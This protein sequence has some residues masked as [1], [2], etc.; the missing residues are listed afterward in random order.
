MLSNT[1]MPVKDKSASKH[2]ESTS[3]KLMKREKLHAM[4]T[5]CHCIMCVLA[6]PIVSS[7]VSFT[8]KTLKLSGCWCF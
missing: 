3:L 6:F 7:L 8:L 2:T 4:G 1:V 5:C